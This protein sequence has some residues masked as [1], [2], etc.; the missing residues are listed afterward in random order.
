VKSGRLITETSEPDLET[1][2]A[3]HPLIS[4]SD[5]GNLIGLPI[6]TLISGLLPNS[7]LTHFCQ[8]AAR[9]NAAM[10][11]NDQEHLAHQIE[12]LVGNRSL[13]LP[14]K[15]IPNAVAAEDLLALCNTL[16]THWT[17]T[18]E[19]IVKIHGLK[20]LNA[21][22]KKGNGA[23]LWR[24]HFVHYA[25]PYYKALADQGFEYTQLSHIRH[26]FSNTRF[27]IRYLN[28]IRTSAE[29]RFIPERV[30][31]TNLAPTAALRALYRRLDSNGIVSIATRG[32]ADQFVET[33]FFNG[34]HKIAPGGPHLAYARDAA[35]LPV[36]PI[37]LADGSHE[38]HILPP[39]ELNK[40]APRRAEI[41][42]T[43]IAF[44]N[45]LE[46]Y[47]IRYPSQWLG[48]MHL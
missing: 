28:P 29:N 12:N 32:N 2:S 26:G 43:A 18:W 31:R 40:N 14:A 5:I 33:P 35:L 39:I 36:F 13:L 20:F 34:T 37:R 1:H 38:I 15:D 24:A 25:F 23:V 21:A 47:V 44:A 41:E 8:V 46:N 48:W 30:E 10:L 4:R 45:I 19:G 7:G 17:H 27:G 9:I 42:R 11:M 22:L 6:L 16:R 3:N